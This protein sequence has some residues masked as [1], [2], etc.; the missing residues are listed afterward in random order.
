MTT[1]RVSTKSDS[2]EHKLRTGINGKGPGRS[3][4]NAETEVRFLDTETDDR[5]AIFW[6]GETQWARRLRHYT[7]SGDI[8]YPIGRKMLATVRASYTTGTTNGENVEKYFYEARVNYRLLKN[9]NL[10]AWWRMEWRNE[11]W[12]AGTPVADPMRREFGWR[13]RE[14]RIEVNYVVFK[15]TCALEYNAYRSVL[16]PYTTEYNRLYLKL[17]RKL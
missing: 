14:Y 11:G 16:G 7:V 12:W 4:W 8:G 15:T 10:L 13:T 17:S 9:L 5:T 6:F 3:Y 1:Y 2:I